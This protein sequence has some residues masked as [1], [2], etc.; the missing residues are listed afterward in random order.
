MEEQEIFKMIDEYGQE[1]N[2]KIL[3]IVEINNQEYL[4]YSLE[5]NEEEEAIYASKLIKNSLGEEEIISIED[6]T[7]RKIVFDTIRELIDELD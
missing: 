1:R 4:V 3:N 7:E 5:K 2:A 6:E